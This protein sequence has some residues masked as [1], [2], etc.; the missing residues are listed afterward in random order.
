MPQCH[1]SKQTQGAV[2]LVRSL[3]RRVP[4]A[5]RRCQHGRKSHTAQTHNL[6]L[7]GPSELCRLAGR[8]ASFLTAYQPFLQPFFSTHLT[9]LGVF[10]KG[11]L[12]RA[13]A[14]SGRICAPFLP[15]RQYSQGV[16]S[17]PTGHVPCH[18]LYFPGTCLFLFLSLSLFF[19][20]SLF[21]FII[22][23]HKYIPFE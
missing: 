1:Y 6:N 17:K 11:L 3:L 4:I 23:L 21:R 7:F 9:V 10:H 20:L 12:F 14:N 13:A 18:Y 19:S 22:Y 16:L 5:S 15:V 2:L 8:A